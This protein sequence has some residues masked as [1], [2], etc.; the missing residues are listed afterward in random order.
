M[1]CSACGVEATGKFCW[2]CGAPLREGGGPAESPAPTA[3]EAPARWDPDEPTYAAVVVVPAVRE[4]LAAEAAAADHPMSA[5]EFLAKCEKVLPQTVPLG[6]LAEIAAPLWAQ[7]GVKT[8]RTETRTVALPAGVALA[9]V[10]VSLAR[11]GNDVKRVEQAEDGCIVHAGIPSTVWH[12]KGHLVVAVRR[13]AS[14]A[15]VE[16]AT[17]IPGQLFDW[18]QSKIRLQALFDDVSDPRVQAA[19]AQ[20]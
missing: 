2:S 6:P 10:L 18:G 17:K 15:S 11:H 20:S 19:V 7:L 12:W 16:A 8:G 9:G 13:E 1:F 5:E 4:L 3:A 14:G